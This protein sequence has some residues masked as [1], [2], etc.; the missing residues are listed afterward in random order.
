MRSKSS[1]PLHAEELSVTKQQVE[2]G[3]VQ[4][5]TVTRVHEEQVDEPLERQHVEIEHVVIDRPIDAVPAV[6]QE[7]DTTIIPVVE[8]VLVVERR[9]RLKEEIHI[10]RVQTT[11]RYRESVTLRRQE[12]VVKRLP[13]K[14][15]PTEAAAAQGWQSN[16]PTKE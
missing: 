16:P 5:G 9:L 7:G 12:A 15:A 4:V 6:R 11:E 1:I 2:T 8:E 14:T 3:R 13:V 10:R